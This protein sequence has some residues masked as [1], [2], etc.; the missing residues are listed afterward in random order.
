MLS[1][2]CVIFHKLCALGSST[3]FLLFEYY[4]LKSLLLYIFYKVETFISLKNIY[5]FI[6]LQS[7][8]G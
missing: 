4:E 3:V 6:S 5:F 2:F 7:I 8:C 1:L